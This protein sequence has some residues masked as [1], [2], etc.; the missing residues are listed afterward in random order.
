MRLGV[1]LTRYAAAGGSEAIPGMLAGLGQAADEAGV[2]VLSLMDHYFQLPY[3]GPADEPILEGYT[4]LGFLAAHTRSVQLQLLVTGVTYRHPGLLA[5]I[6]A[7]LDVLSRG[8]AALGIGAGWYE[9]EHRGLGVPFPPLRDRFGLLEEALQV[10][11]QMW[12]HDDGPFRG[13][14]YQLEETLCS[15]RPLRPPPVMIGGV[16]ERK[17]LRLVAAYADACNLFAGGEQG[18][19]FVAG[20]LAVLRE[21]CEQEGTAYD[22][23]LK[24]I[25][26]TPAFDPAAPEIFLEQ[27]Q[28]MAEVGV[29]EVHVMPED[30]PVR[31]V[32]TL[33]KHVA[34]AL[35]R[36]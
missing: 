27:M 29:E 7:S 35:R 5:K 31:F 18:A 12:S 22:G 2:D 1:H 15:P 17:T 9:R 4:T 13:E 32:Q 11:R 14:H 16:G 20:K 28:A 19:G 34:P 21:H 8:R 24:T 3:L 30:D 25:L 10:V 36:L 33:G 23:I 26:W 6:V